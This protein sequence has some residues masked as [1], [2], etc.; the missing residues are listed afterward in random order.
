MK[1]TF[2]VVLP[3]VMAAQVTSLKTTVATLERM[4]KTTT[5]RV[6]SIENLFS[7]GSCGGAS[8]KVR[9]PEKKTTQLLVRKAP[10]QS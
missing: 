7:L 10:Q 8:S 1:T 5:E 6:A 2:S 4:N 9:R 3:M